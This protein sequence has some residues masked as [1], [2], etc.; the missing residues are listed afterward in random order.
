MNQK[1]TT[2]RLV[3]SLALLAFILAPTLQNKHCVVDMCKTCRY[4]NIDTCEECESGYYLKQFYGE[5]KKRP[6][7]ACWHWWKALLGTLLSLLLCLSYCYCCYKA[8]KKGKLVTRLTNKKL[9]K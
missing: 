4:V 6:Y 5:E 3:S 2:K 9:G 8:W 7:Q 1:N